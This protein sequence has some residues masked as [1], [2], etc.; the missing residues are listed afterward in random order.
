M[1]IY[2]GLNQFVAAAAAAAIGVKTL[3]LSA[4]SARENSQLLQERYKTNEEL[5]IRWIGAGFIES[6]KLDKLD[7]FTIRKVG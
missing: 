3:G 1:D 2:D 4:S 7:G 6:W 5:G